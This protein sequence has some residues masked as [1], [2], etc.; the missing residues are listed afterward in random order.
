M[1]RPH[2]EELEVSPTI[3][4][5]F[6]GPK[7]HLTNEMTLKDLERSLK[8]SGEAKNLVEFFDS[9]GSRLATSTRLKNVLQMPN[10]KMN[11]DTAIQ[12]HCHSSEGFSKSISVQT[13]HE[14]NIYL[15]FK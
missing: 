8:Q 15:Q 7:I 13:P 11:I 2:V 9:D 5:R 12:Y 1:L 10:F 14:H 3:Q 6:M 4:L